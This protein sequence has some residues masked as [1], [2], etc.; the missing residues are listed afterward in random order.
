[1]SA[2]DSLHVRAA[3]E[4]RELPLAPA[5]LAAANTSMLTDFLAKRGLALNTR[6]GG[7]GLCSG[8]LV[9]I[10]RAGG[11]HE[12]A[13]ACRMP[14][15]EAVGAAAE[16][17]VIS[18]PSRSLLKQQPSVVDDFRVNIPMA[19][20]PLVAGARYGA[21]VDVGTTTV[22]VIV[23]DFENG[24]VLARA[25][26]FN[27][28]IRFGEDVLTRIQHCC[29]N[30]APAVRELQHALMAETIQ[31]LIEKACARA[32][33]AKG[34]VG[35]IAIA[36]NTTMQH[37]AA[38]VDPAPL[39]AH[40]FTPAFLEHRV[41]SAE[42]LGLAWR[43]LPVHLLPGLSSY[44]GADL[45]A[46]LIATGLIYE[47]GPSL[48]VDVGTNGEIIAKTG[49]RIVGCAT[50]AGPAFEGAGLSCGMRAARGAIERVRMSV[51]ADGVFE[52]R[53]DVIGSGES[54]APL[55]PIGMC[56]SAYIDFL[57]EAR[58]AGLLMPNGRFAPREKLPAG[59]CVEVDEHGKKF[60][61]HEHG[62]SG[63]LW[64]SEMDVVKLL[65]AK[66]AIGAGI[67][68]LL[69]VLGIK[70]RDIKRLYLAGGFGMH[71]SLEHAIGCGLLPGFA[72]E[73]IEV[74]GNTSL[75]GAYLAINDKSLLD[76]M[77]AARKRFEAVEL[78]LHPNFED[79]YIDNLSLE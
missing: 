10:E 71:L 74:V 57:W 1:M 5:D 8:C 24:K 64:I 20:D 40:P 17:A 13:R 31:P 16:N 38:D 58:R 14:L 4:T 51:N 27:A 36:G 73:Q 54:S 62:A 72:P 35:A 66:A 25:S 44:V 41:Y 48:L 33:I 69:D 78:N 45:T 42:A 15:A 2:A 55:K 6:C 28:Q 11:K 67:C 26:A 22:A 9:E 61:I 37:L 30:G 18:I 23:C 70:A 53:L 29:T 39:G 32:G 49:D 50:A 65:Q 19:R 59:V 60:R 56:G 43:G 76:E 7:R 12:Q 34:D 77:E 75:G 46:G 79:A 68:T 52:M 63:P 21:A 3:D 47:D